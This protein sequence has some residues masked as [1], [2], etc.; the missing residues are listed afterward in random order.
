MRKVAGLKSL[1]GLPSDF[2]GTDFFREENIGLI[3]QMVTLLSSMT[4]GSDSSAATPEMKPY[5]H[6]VLTY[7]FCLASST[8]FVVFLFSLTSVFSLWI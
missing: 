6:E 4:S 2:T 3:E 8:S 5:L 7:L 1:F